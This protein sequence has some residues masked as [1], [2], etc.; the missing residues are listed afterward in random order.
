MEPEKGSES[1]TLVVLRRTFSHVLT[2]L[3][4]GGALTP[5]R[6]HCF[7][8]GR[9]LSRRSIKSGRIWGPPVSGT[10]GHAVTAQPQQEPSAPL[11][12]PLSRHS[13]G[14]NPRRKEVTDLP[15]VT[16][17]I[18]PWTRPGEA[19]PPGSSA[20]GSLNGC[21]LYCNFLKQLNSWFA[22]S[23]GPNGGRGRGR[24]SASSTPTPSPEAP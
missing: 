2:R 20:A 1:R 18:L 23:L 13:A 14:E 8:S 4:S 7:S 17:H 9:S 11:V 10:R 12:M 22:L 3:R 21:R 6:V 15:K 24:S 19:G 5:T 16:K